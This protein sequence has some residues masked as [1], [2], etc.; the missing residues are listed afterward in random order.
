L[1]R[2]PSQRQRMLQA[3]GFDKPVMPAPAVVAAPPSYAPVSAP[4]SVPVAVESTPVAALP[5]TAPAQSTGLDTAFDHSLHAERAPV[6]PTTL[7]R[8]VMPAPSVVAAPSETPAFAPP[9][10][11]VAVE[12]TPVVAG[13]ASDVEPLERLDS[14]LDLQSQAQFAPIA[15]TTPV[16]MAPAPIVADERI[17]IVLPERMPVADPHV[18]T[19]S[20][21]DRAMRS[22]GALLKLPRERLRSLLC[23]LPGVDADVEDLMSAMQAIPQEAWPMFLGQLP[24][25]MLRALGA[26]EV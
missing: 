2:D 11:P 18:T 26:L 10:V 20:E 19:G 16:E 17:P 6:A 13:A 24:A 23:T 25:D 7:I 1:L 5:A 4:P 3:L 21:R 14:A 8:P 9:S 12:S 15:P 22:L